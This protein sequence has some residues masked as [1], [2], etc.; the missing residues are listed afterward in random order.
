MCKLKTSGRK[1]FPKWL[2]DHVDKGEVY[3]V[4]W[5]D[6]ENTIFRVPWTR[7]DSP[8][9]DL[10][11]D[12]KLFQLWAEFTGRYREGERTD[13]SVWKTRFRCAIRKM[14]EIEEIT[15]AKHLEEKNGRQPFRVFRFKKDGKYKYKL[16][17]IDNISYF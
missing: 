5:L 11:R 2:Y 6:K 12:A 1:R 9:F 10:A 17:T 13:P 15:S 16:T 7:V 4:Y 3:G 14:A 8:D